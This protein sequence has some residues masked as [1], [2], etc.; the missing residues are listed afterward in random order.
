MNRYQIFALNS[1]GLLLPA[2]TLSNV[3]TGHLFSWIF[4]IVLIMVVFLLLWGKR[5]F[6]LLE[7]NNTQSDINADE[8]N[9][10]LK[11]QSREKKSLIGFGVFIGIML[12]LI[13]LIRLGN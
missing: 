13:T 6:R 4:G 12:L 5:Y 11:L 10:T 2:M 1:C 8:H 7:E 9:I 3:L